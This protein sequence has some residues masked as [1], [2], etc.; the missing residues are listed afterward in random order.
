[1]RGDCYICSDVSGA[2]LKT[3]QVESC[4]MEAESERNVHVAAA[5]LVGVK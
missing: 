3:E 2:G 4:L 5:V 1:M